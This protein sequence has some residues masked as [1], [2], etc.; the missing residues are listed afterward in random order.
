MQN[1]FLFLVVFFFLLTLEAQQ[2]TAEIS[3]L[4][5]EKT[6]ALR[7]AKGLEPFKP[8]DSLNRLAQYHSDN[9]VTKAFY[10]HIDPEGLNPVTRA[11]KLGIEA[12]QKKGNRRI[13]IAE[14]IA[15]VPWFSNVLGCGDTRSSERFA[16]C[17][18]MGWKNSPPHYKNMMGDYR[19]LGVGLQFDR[20][21]MGFGTQVFR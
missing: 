3:Q 2:K 1:P 7:V 12:W 5:F 17:M 13:G 11:E 9:M 10:S 20:A 21:N 18:V 4:I 19:Y 8:L 15:Q 16:E 14:N 6:N